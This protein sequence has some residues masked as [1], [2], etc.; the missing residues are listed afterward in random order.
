MNVAC[1]PRLSWPSFKFHIFNVHRLISY[2]KDFFG[3]GRSRANESST[4]PFPHHS[5]NFRKNCFHIFLG[6]RRYPFSNLKD[7][8]QVNRYRRGL[9]TCP[10]ANTSKSGHV[11]FFSFYRRVRRT[12]RTQRR[13]ENTRVHFWTFPPVSVNRQKSSDFLY[14]SGYLKYWEI[15]LR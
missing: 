5:H 10:Q 3:N 15:R 4:A 8:S 7:K 1:N 6:I 14:S 2:S 13:V 9:E 12:S 11:F